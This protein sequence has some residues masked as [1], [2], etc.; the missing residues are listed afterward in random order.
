MILLTFSEISKKYTFLND[1]TNLKLIFL[2][3]LSLLI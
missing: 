2:D 3:D 1:A